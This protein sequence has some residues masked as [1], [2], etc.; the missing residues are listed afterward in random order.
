[1]EAQRSHE[2]CDECR[3]DTLGEAAFRRLRGEKLHVREKA[4]IA[5]A[6]LSGHVPSDIGE[7]RAQ[8]D[9]SN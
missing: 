4:I 8:S 1:V 5:A 7:P 2:E 6:G 9:P 3:L